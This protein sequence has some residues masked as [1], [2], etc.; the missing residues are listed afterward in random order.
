MKR[1]GS[2][3]VADLILCSA[4]GL[5]NM[6][7]LC[8]Y[9]TQYIHHI[10]YLCSIYLCL[11]VYV[12]LHVER[13]SKKLLCLLLA[14]LLRSS[15]GLADK[16]ENS[17]WLTLYWLTVRVSVCVCV[18]VCLCVSVCVHL[19]IHVFLCCSVSIT[20][21]ILGHISLQVQSRVAHKD[22]SNFI[23]RLM[24]SLF[25]FRSSNETILSRL[26]PLVPTK[27]TPD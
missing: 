19:P 12:L 9:Y 3:F 5:Y 2:L 18:C 10:Y 26:L 13:I 6:Y 8:I 27:P 14:F 20:F 25:G 22:I 23:S 7:V 1:A 24:V 4:W 17:K 21:H 15:C 11:S 16:V